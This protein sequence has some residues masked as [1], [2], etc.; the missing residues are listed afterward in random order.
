MVLLPK[1]KGVEEIMEERK[2]LLPVEASTSLFYNTE[3][4]KFFAISIIEDNDF[5]T[6]EIRMVEI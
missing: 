5:E 2:M 3:T 6:Y 1:T 4:K